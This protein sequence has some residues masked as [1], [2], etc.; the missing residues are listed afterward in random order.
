MMTERQNSE[1][2]FSPTAFGKVTLKEYGPHTD[3][4]AAQNGWLRGNEISHS[5]RGGWEISFI[6][7]WGR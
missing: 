4:P 2:N 5:S 7:K 3:L 6:S 1:L